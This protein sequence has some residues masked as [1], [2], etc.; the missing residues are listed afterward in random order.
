MRVR[1]GQLGAIDKFARAIVV[2]PVFSGLE[3]VDDGVAGGG[4]VL[5][6]MLVWRR[7]AAADVAALG[8]AAQ[9]QPPTVLC[10]AFDATRAAGFRVQIYAFSLILHK[11]S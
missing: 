10:H 4:V 8:A 3:A 6:G 2:E 7:I 1:A 11:I 9:M 5:G